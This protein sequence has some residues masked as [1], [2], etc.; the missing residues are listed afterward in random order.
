VFPLVEL[1]VKILRQVYFL[2]K[3][4]VRQYQL[5]SEISMLA[6]YGHFPVGA[7]NV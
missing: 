3:V 1:L 6:A 4:L 7:Y 5:C 2:E